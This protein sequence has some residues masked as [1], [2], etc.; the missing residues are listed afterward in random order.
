V[1]RKGSLFVTIACL[2]FVVQGL[3][4]GMIGVAWPSVRETFAL[5]LDAVGLLLVARVT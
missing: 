3:P 2:T 1:K 5:P 4:A